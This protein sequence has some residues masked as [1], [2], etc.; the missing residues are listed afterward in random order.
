MRKKVIRYG[1]L[2]A[3]LLVVGGAGFFAWLVANRQRIVKS[4]G[5]V[6]RHRITSGNVWGNR[7]QP[8]G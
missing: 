7:Q 6:F 8:R 1:V 3:L 2:G 4:R 5:G